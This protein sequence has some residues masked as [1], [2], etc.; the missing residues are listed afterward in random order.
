[1][2]ALIIG[3]EKYNKTT[4]FCIHCGEKQ[5]WSA[6]EM[7]Y[8]KGYQL[9]CCLCLSEWYAY[10]HVKDEY[11]DGED[12]KGVVA[13]KINSQHQKGNNLNE[14]I[15]CKRCESD[16][17]Y[18]K[19]EKYEAHMKKHEKDDFEYYKDIRENPHKYK[20]SMCVSS[21]LDEE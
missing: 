16:K 14:Y 13:K 3:G 7:D 9:V 21:L 8:E 15:K 1:M 18:I 20:S 2:E 11:D 5:V 19:Q 6:D 10:G 4:L 12:E 17:P